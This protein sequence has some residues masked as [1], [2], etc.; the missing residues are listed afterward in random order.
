MSHTAGFAYGLYGSDPS[1]IAFIKQG[2]LGSPDLGTF[3]AKVA[4]VPLITQPGKQWFYSAAVDI[5]G[6]IIERISGMTFG[7]YLQQKIFT[8]LRMED[9]GFYV[10]AEDYD[11][12][13]DVFAYHPETKKFQRLPFDETKYNRLGDVSFKREVPR[14]ESGGGGL[15]STL[16]DYARFCQMLIDQGEF[17]GQRILR[18]ETIN[19]MRT[20]VLVDDQAVNISGTLSAAQSAAIGFGLNV[21]TIRNSGDG[22][23]LLGDGSYFWGGAAGTWFWIDPK[24][25]LYFIGMM[26]RVPQGGP[27]V[28]FRG[29]SQKLVYG[30]LR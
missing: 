26:Q 3:I 5:Q 4:T 21:G 13:S 23:I 2:I 29:E 27:E 14:M 16:S 10:P 20:D 22:G 24:N 30:A 1:N 12:F 9:T 8:P 11:R 6:A 25:D 28:D 19:L 17:E 15:V 18:P 7:E